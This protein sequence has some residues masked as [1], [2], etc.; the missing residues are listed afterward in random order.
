M[1]AK[2]DWIEVEESGAFGEGD[3][4][5]VGFTNEF[6]PEFP[7]FHTSLAALKTFH[8]QLG[9]LIESESEVYA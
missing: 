3:R 4:F 5:Y 8:E 6:D 7:W 9:K 2:L 1:S